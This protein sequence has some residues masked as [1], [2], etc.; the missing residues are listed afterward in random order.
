MP[1]ARMSSLPIAEICGGS[2]R[3]S[4]ESNWRIREG[5]IGRAYHLWFESKYGPR[6]DAR[7]ELD[8]MLGTMLDE[9]RAV[10]AELTQATLMNFLPPWQDGARLDCEHRVALNEHCEPVGYDDAEAVARGTLDIGWCEPRGLENHDT[11]VVLDHKTGHWVDVERHLLQLAGYGIA[12]A[13]ARKKRYLALYIHIVRRAKCVSLQLGVDAEGLPI[14]LL[15]L[16]SPA[17]SVLWQRVLVAATNDDTEFVTG[18]HCEECW[19]RL[20]CPARLLPASTMQEGLAPLAKGEDA[21]AEEMAA[22]LV[23][24]KA[25]KDVAAR[26]FESAEAWVRRRGP[27]VSGTQVFEAYET[28]GRRS[29]KVDD[30]IAA[31]LGQ[32]VNPGTPGVKFGWHRAKK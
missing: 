21:T 15:D 5:Q 2:K 11:A 20:H 29:A 9:D 12:Y 27:I 24:A 7:A 22:V 8:S 4:A 3:L 28:A 14:Y 6:E 10:V 25:M 17:A 19:E 32:Y 31:G 18:G 1:A 23:A 30:L 16:E 26:A 13:R